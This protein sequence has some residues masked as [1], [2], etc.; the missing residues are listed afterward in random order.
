MAMQNYTIGRNNDCHIRV[1]EHLDRISR[2]HAT[3]K[4]MDNGKMFVVD[5][6]MNG[7]YVNGIKITPHVDYPVKRND[8]ISFANDYE[9]DWSMIAK[10]KRKRLVYLLFSIAAVVVIG[11]GIVLFFL[12]R[13]NDES[14]EQ[15]P[16]YN[17]ISEKQL[18]PA[19]EEEEEVVAQDTVDVKKPDVQKLRS[20]KKKEPA[21]ADTTKVIIF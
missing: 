12:L 8:N 16:S 18:Y 11:I 10:P 17:V 5:N 6:S 13:A 3:L 1:P 9:L 14:E 2:E 19:E 21:G 4:V 7:T 20:D 15:I